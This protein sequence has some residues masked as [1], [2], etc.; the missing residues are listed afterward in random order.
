MDHEYFL[1]L[2]YN[3]KKISHLKGY[4]ACFRWH[5]NNKTNQTGRNS[6]DW[7]KIYNTYGIKVSN[8]KKIN[9]FV[10]KSLRNF[11]MILRALY[12]LKMFLIGKIKGEKFGTKIFTK[13]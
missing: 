5:E 12:K 2:I 13:P 6:P 11:Y 7:S 1:R 10:H 4:M 3:G 9:Y 8:N